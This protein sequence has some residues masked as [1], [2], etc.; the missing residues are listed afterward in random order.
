MN[1]KPNFKKMSKIFDEIQVNAGVAEG[2]K[3]LHWFT[4]ILIL[5]DFCAVFC[6]FMA[7]GPISGPREWLIG[8]AL[9]TGRHKYFAYVL[10]SQ[11]FVTN[12]ANKN[13]L[14]QSGDK[15]DVN[16]IDFVDYSGVTVYKNEYEK[17]ILEHNEGDDYKIIS[18]S[19]GSYS[20]YIAV[21]YHPEKLDL[22]VAQ[23][24]WGNEVSEM[25]EQNNGQLGVNGGG[26]YV[27]LD[28]YY[29]Y[30][31]DNLIING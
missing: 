26:Y 8:T 17:E 11:K 20:G 4:K 21:I 10:Y 23:R 1:K 7:Y 31:T 22:V 9:G 13:T 29:K 12:V 28:T 19:N 2:K 14:I 3:K 15:S 30:P 24:K 6:F 5:V 25:V 16:S 27:D 18:I